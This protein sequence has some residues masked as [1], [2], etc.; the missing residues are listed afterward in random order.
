MSFD[1][2]YEIQLQNQWKFSKFDHPA[3]YKDLLREIQ[4]SCLPQKHSHFVTVRTSPQL[5]IYKFLKYNS[6]VFRNIKLTKIES[7][8]FVKFPKNKFLNLNDNEHLNNFASIRRKAFRG[9]HICVKIDLFYGDMLLIE[10]MTFF[11][12][13]QT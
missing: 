9:L 3:C 4:L 7:N 11:L 6:F 10:R 8:V 2:N 5:R 13:F 12:S 1:T